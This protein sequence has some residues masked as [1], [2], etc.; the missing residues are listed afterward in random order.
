VALVDGRMRIIE[1]IDLPDEVARRTDAAGTLR[2]WA[3]SMGVHV[4]NV[5]F[6]RRAAETR[7]SLPFHLARKVVP[8]IDAAGNAVV[9]EQ[10]NAIKFERFIFDLLPEAQRTL[11]VEADAAESFAPVKN[12]SGAAKDSPEQTEQ[13]LVARA[14][15]WLTA[16]GAEVDPGVA[17]E[18]SPLFALDAEA[19]GGR[20]M[21]GTRIS[22]GT[23]L[24]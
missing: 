19:L 15:R 18:I 16:A 6:L 23:Y 1:Y 2:L 7:G 9:P 4:F 8:T 5:S 11:A 24:R 21:P 17:V 10:P 20:V 12:A 14:R 13:A 3:G 22:T